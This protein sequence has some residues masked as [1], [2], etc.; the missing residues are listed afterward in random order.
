MSLPPG[1]PGKLILSKNDG[2]PSNFNHDDV[3]RFRYFFFPRT[4]PIPRRAPLGL[5]QHCFLPL[6]VI[7]RRRTKA[8]H[9]RFPPSFFFFLF[10]PDLFL[11]L[12]LKKTQTP[13]FNGSNKEFFSFLGAP[14]FP[15]DLLFTVLKHLFPWTRLL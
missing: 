8:L 4:Q 6:F 12:L 15:S 11:F 2:P 9:S 3:L 13:S 14:G 7:P 1:S 10:S 5:L